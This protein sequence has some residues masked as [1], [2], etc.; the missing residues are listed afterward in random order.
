MWKAVLAGLVAWVMIILTALALTAVGAYA[1]SW[2]PLSCCSGMDCI[3]IPESAVRETA[4]GY[5]IV[6]TGEVIAHGDPRIKV[7]PPEDLDQ[8]YHWCR[9]LSDGSNTY[10]GKSWKK[11]DTICLFVPGR[12]V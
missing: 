4:K 6:E 10:T 1:H 9:K 5:V 11:G 3:P 2:Y 8:G 7:T 12:G